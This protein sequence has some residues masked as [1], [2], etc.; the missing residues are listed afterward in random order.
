MNYRLI[1]NEIIRT[2][3]KYHEEPSLVFN[4]IFFKKTETLLLESAKTNNKKSIESM[5][6]ADTAIK[7]YCFDNI[8]KI[9]AISNDGLHL[10]NKIDLKIFNKKSINIKKKM[11]YIRNSFSYF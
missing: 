2:V 1:K 5:L 11:E 4:K 8:V 7:I 6:I 3:C 10:L 9:K